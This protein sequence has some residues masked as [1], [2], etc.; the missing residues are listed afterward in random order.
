MHTVTLALEGAWKVLV[1]GLLLGAGLPTIFAFGVRALAHG[2]SGDSD[3]HAVA[4]SGPN[5][6]GWSV[7]VVCFAIVVA[8]AGLGIT[9]IVASGLGQQL[10]FEHI[11]PTLVHKK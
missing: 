8:A 6:V 7:A 1:A 4:R 10:S 3:T 11:Y 5:A 9:Y 2:H